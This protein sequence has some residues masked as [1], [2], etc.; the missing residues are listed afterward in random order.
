MCPAS[1]SRTSAFL[2]MME[3][4]AC[5]DAT[6]MVSSLVLGYC[7]GW[8]RASLNL[9]VQRAL[10]GTGMGSLAALRC[11]AG[12]GPDMKAVLTCVLKYLK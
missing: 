4:L 9:K 1:H 8:K 10:Q 7:A 12:D 5:L 2:A 6:G 3:F 11:C